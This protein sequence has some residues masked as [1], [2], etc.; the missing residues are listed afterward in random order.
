MFVNKIFI[1][2]TI[3]FI[4]III[5]CKLCIIYN[6]TNN[7]KPYIP[8]NNNDNID[9]NKP[10][11]PTNNNDNIDNNKPDIPTNNNDNIDNNK[12]DIPTNN[13]DNI[14]NN[15]P[16]N[17]NVIYVNDFNE[18]KYYCNNAKPGDIINLKQNTTYYGNLEINNINGTENNMIYILGDNTSTID[19]GDN[20]KSRIITLKN[21]SYIYIG[22]NPS[23]ISNNNNGE[24]FN[25]KNG[26]KGLYISNCNNIIIQ[27]LNVYDIGMEG[28]HL[29]NESCFCLIANNKVY[30]TGLF[31]PDYGEGL[32]CGTAVSNWSSSSRTPE[33]IGKPDKSDNNIF[34]YNYCYNN[35]GENIDIK[36]GTR[37]GIVRYNFFNGNKLKNDNSADS[38]IDIKGQN[39]EIYNNKMEITLIDGIQTHK[40]NI[41]EEFIKNYYINNIYYPAIESGCYNKIY[42][43]NM[44][45]ITNENIKCTG[46]AIN[47]NSATIGNIICNNNIYFNAVKGLCNKSITNCDS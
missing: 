22:K 13:N 1:F 17:N 31:N 10:D 38:W 33:L 19:G 41:P 32:Y 44:D 42:A 21:C 18:L 46:Y 40:T 43:N 3:I 6:N 45:C 29:L 8:T 24:G 7:N 9:N 2:I 39:W 34:E 37:N 25:I 4:I 28:I 15:K 23:N 11:I 47:I 16:N 35:T 27:N 14:D 36:E 30:N 20:S 26:Q 12:P 5:C